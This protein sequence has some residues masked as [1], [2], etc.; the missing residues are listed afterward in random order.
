[1]FYLYRLVAH[2]FYFFIIFFRTIDEHN[3]DY[4]K[5]MPIKFW[6]LTIIWPILLLIFNETYKV[7]EIK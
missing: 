6:I 1:M 5:N 3:I 4:F 2:F 7:F